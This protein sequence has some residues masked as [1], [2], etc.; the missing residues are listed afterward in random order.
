MK[1]RPLS[2]IFLLAVVLLLPTGAVKA[3]ASSAAAAVKVPQWLTDEA[4]R[5]LRSFPPE[6]EAVVLLDERATSVDLKGVLTT[7]C[8][9]AT[10]ILRPA[11]VESARR[12]VL[13][14][15]YDTKVKAMTGWVINP[16]GSPRQV[17]MKEVISSSLAADTL[18]M[19]AKLMLL[20][21]PEADTGSVVGFEWREERT[22][23]ALEDVVDIQG[24]FPVLRSRY[25]L[26]LPRLWEPEMGW[27][28]WP[29][30]E[31]IEDPIE[32]LRRSLEILDV[33]AVGDEP[34]M[35]DKRALAGRLVVRIKPQAGGPHVFAGWADM[36]AWYTGLSEPRRVPDVKVTAKARELASAAADPLSR[37]AALA[38]FVQKEIRYVSVQ[39]GVGG[40]QPHFAA[41]ILKN[42]YGDCKDKATLL[43]ALLAAS[44]FDSHYLI[45]NTSRG[46]VT[47]DSPVSLYGFNHAILA[48]RLPE[49]VPDAGLDS[50]IRHPRLGRL[51]VFDPT[52]PTTPLG[53]L[54]YYLQDNTA[55]LVDGAGSELIL[56][57][58]PAPESNALDRTGRLVLSG[59][60]TLSGEIREKRQGAAADSLRYQ[61][62]A[63]SEADRRKYLETF[64]AQSLGAFTL[65]SFEFGDLEN[66]G[67]DL[68]VSYRIIAPAY[69]KRAGDYLVLR[70]RVV[71]TKTVDLVSRDKNPRRHPIDLET[72]LLARDEFTVE[73]PRGYAIESIPSPV[74]LD[75][76]FAS[77]RSRSEAGDGSLVYRREYRLVE[78]L[79]P[80]SRFDQALAFFLAV[81]AE[82]QQSL[83]LKIGGDRRPPCP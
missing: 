15:T 1:N 24:E 14:E 48:V 60:G 23:P 38:R 53:R 74:G 63:A 51:L 9:R 59:D 32:P 78:P 79:L 22:P 7:F 33:P 55:L 66:A 77:Y 13:A 30:V 35:P 69:A 44:G 17:T 12:L 8:R 62:Q 20:L 34:R 37:I 27:V 25:T 40:F 21:V 64:L 10:R 65:Q 76:G 50:L 82:E 71:G 80:A 41:D 49:D 45:V 46:V 11:G 5:G 6:T 75:A 83:L 28:H 29:A 67:S 43:S 57:P 61:M 26:T 58:R 36:G 2:V 73:L 68:L 16:S 56:L 47:P 54:P 52:M 31:A 39:I 18:Y 72:T 42:R 4:A 70:P 3:G 19:D 81:S